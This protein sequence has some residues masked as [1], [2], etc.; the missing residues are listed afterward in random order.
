MKLL[1]G[2]TV[3][4]LL[5]SNNLLFLLINFLGLI[6]CQSSKH[7]E[8]ERLP[9]YNT[10][11]FD[12]EW[13]SSTAPGYDTIHTIAPFSLTNQLGH[14]IT[15]DSLDGHIYVAN[16]FFSTCPSICPK[17]MSNLK[18]LQKSLSDTSNLKMVSFSVMPWVDSVSRL[19]SYGDLHGINPRRWY[20][21]TGAKE[22]I[23]TLGRTSYFAEKGLGLQKNTSEFM[24]TESMLLIDKKGRIRGVYN[25]TQNVD[26]ERITEDIHTL[27]NEYKI[28][29]S[30]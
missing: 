9:F 1:G 24:H 18:T 21:L 4:Q 7:E 14:T 2:M 10:A 8:V 27:E 5:K 12:A 11:T 26:I 22:E 23:Y 17:M 15:K 30:S 20:L 19:R 3:C 6:S 25:A 28:G 29:T 16:F 13:I